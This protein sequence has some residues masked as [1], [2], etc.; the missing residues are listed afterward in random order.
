MWVKEEVEEK[1]RGEPT[2]EEEEEILRKAMEDSLRTH[3][4]EEGRRCPGLH[5]VL[6][7]SAEEA[8]NPPPP[9]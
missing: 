7:L 2:E 3:A 8:H 9:L 6:L 5:D 4:E 1:Q